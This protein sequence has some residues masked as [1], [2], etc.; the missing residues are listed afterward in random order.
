MAELDPQQCRL[1]SSPEGDQP[2]AR[3]E[4]Q[5]FAATMLVTARQQ[6]PPDGGAWGHHA[7]PGS[8]HRPADGPGSVFQGQPGVK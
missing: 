4:L 7:N 1:Q 3:V 6:L 8:G 2:A 5:D